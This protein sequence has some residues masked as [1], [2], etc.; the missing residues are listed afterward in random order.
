LASSSDTQPQINAVGAGQRCVEPPG[1]SG[2]FDVLRGASDR[3]GLTVI[4]DKGYVSRELDGYLA[5]RGVVLLRS[6]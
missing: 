1:V 3:P 6:S 4:A 2:D 5:D